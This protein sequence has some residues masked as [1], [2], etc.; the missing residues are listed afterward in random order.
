MIPW[1]GAYR[2]ERCVYL[3]HS[4][5]FTR[6]NFL[7]DKLLGV[8]PPFDM[9]QDRVACGLDRSGVKFP[10]IA[11]CALPVDRKLGILVGLVTSDKGLNL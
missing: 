5:D 1:K 3:R 9:L 11:V 7:N 2:S 4:C 8:E 10:P 6:C